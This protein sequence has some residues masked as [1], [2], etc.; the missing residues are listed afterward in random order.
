MGVTDTGTLHHIGFVVKDLEK[1]AKALARD[2]SIGPRSVWTIAP[3]VGT[4]RG[5]K[6]TFSFR[7][8]LAPFGGISYELLEPVSC[9]NVYVE[10]LESKGEGFHHTHFLPD[11]GGDADRQIGA[12]RPGARNDPEWQP[13]RTR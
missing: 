9:D 8:A 12:S 10:H 5:R 11:S 13:W 2:L 4:V 6:V 7:V 3:E 1:A